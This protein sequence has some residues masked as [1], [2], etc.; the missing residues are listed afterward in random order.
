MIPHKLFLQNFLSYQS[1]PEP[2][3]FSNM[4]LVALIGANGHGKSALLDA[5]TWA[6]W[7]KARARNDALVHMGRGSAQVIFEFRLEGQ[8]YSVTR[9]YDRRSRKTALEFAVW[10]DSTQRWQSL[11]ESSLKAT[12]K[13]I[14]SLLRIDY[15]TFIHTAFLKQGEADKFTTA[16][17]SKRKEILG[18]ILNLSEYDGYAQRARELAKETQRQVDLL[19][20]RQQKLE[21]ELAQERTRREDLQRAEVKELQTRLVKDETRKTEL[22][23]RLTLQ[24]LEDKRSMREKLA[25]RVTR[26]QREFEH[27]TEDRKNARERVETLKQLLEQKEVIEQRFR[28]WQ[29]AQAEEARWNQTLAAL[30]PL[31]KEEQTLMRAIDK[32]R[33]ELEKQL[34]IKT[35]WLHEAEKAAAILSDLESQTIELQHTVQSLEALEAENQ[36]RAQRLAALTVELQNRREELSRL[37][38]LLDALPE[39]E[40]KWRQ[41]QQEVTTLETLADEEKTRTQRI[42]EIRTIIH[43]KE[44]ELE[45]LTAEATALKERLQL[46]EQGKT[47]ACPVCQRPLGESDRSHVLQEYEN[48]L[49][50]LRAEFQQTRKTLHALQTEKKELEAISQRTVKR[51]RRLPGLQRQLA[52]LESRL[53]AYEGDSS[54]L[55]EQAT[56]LQATIEKLETEERTLKKERE[57]T[58]SLLHD[59]PRHRRSLSQLEGRLAEAQRKASRAE[60]LRK[61]VNDL[62]TRLVAGVAPDLQAQLA[63][64]QAQL[65]RIT[66][67]ADAHQRARQTRERWQDIPRLWQQVLEA[68]KRLPEEAQTLKRI[69]SRWRR[70]KAALLED[71]AELATL[72]EA[73]K[74]LPDARAQWQEAH[75]AAE[76]AHQAWELANQQLAAARMRLDALKEVRK[77]YQA[78]QQELADVKAQ[79]HRY[80][81]LEV[82]FGKNGLQAMLIEA[83]LPELENEANRLLARLTEGRMHVRLETQREKK[84]GGVQEALDIIISDELGSRPYELYSGGEAFRVNL[85]LRIALSRL[86]AR[87]AGAALQ[88]LFIDEG[89]GTQDTQGRENLVDAMHM[90]KDEFGLILVITHIDELK[91]QFPVRILVEKT[92]AG[93][94]YHIT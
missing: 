63:A 7:G 78:L 58:A 23:A 20:G 51:L 33:T 14:D 34:A 62:Q 1:P 12:Q 53:Q 69:E 85:A 86:L 3:D 50:R 46:L 83:A 93:S 30:R 82:A 25:A 36:I 55:I 22:Q 61:E 80:Q 81:T 73:L 28:E 29:R 11:T 15:E 37:Q 27:T 16:L 43:Q 90:I 8:R 70:E 24:G 92:E 26:A 56:D 60:D 42:T 41:L 64:V 31:E 89:F 44:Q 79:L 18:R 94:I 68:E 72:D 57:V 9:K 87:R 40:A 17:P 6:L 76:Q 21:E 45:A 38:T 54:L 75:R 52:Q 10:D 35:D 74:S 13:K 65:T 48:Q 67:D 39:L 91:D 77:Q 84:S 71:M 32:A 19:A 49:Q 47:D 88:A 59:L 2:L 5:M 66:Y 4:H